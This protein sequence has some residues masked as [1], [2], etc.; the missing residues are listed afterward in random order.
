MNRFSISTISIA[1]FLLC[2]T[3]ATSALLA[4]APRDFAVTDFGALGDGTTLNTAAIQAAIDKAA[5]TPDGGRVVIP[6]GVFRSGSIFLKNGAELYL[7]AEA[8]LLGSNDIA[9]Y[10]KRDTR[11]EGHVE[12]WRMALVNAQNLPRVRI[13]GPGK[14][15]GNGA[16]FWAEFGRRIRENRKTTNLDVERPRLMFVDTCSDVRISGLVLRD[17]GFWNVHLY[18]CRDVVVED[19]DIAISR[20]KGRGPSTDGLDLDSCRDVIVRRCRFAVDD[21]CIAIKGSKGPLADRDE[22]SP[23]VENILIEKCTFDAGHGVVTFGSEATIVRGVTVRDC[24]VN[25]QNSVVRLKLRPD[26][27]QLYE[28][29]LYENIRLNADGGALISARPWLQYF[30]LKGH[31]SPPSVVRNLTIRNITGRYG[32]FGTLN[33][34]ANDIIDG[35]TL[36]NIDVTLQK[37]KLDTGAMVKNF[38][39][40]AVKVNGAKYEL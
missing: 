4:A 13:G 17:S 6:K 22:A 24:D 7:A 15:D 5:A 12:P 40:N 32:S 10:P 39:V 26:T 11:I 16:T 14:I 21:D 18:R 8:V 34:N 38:K 20:E 27:P 9:D 28:N 29:I 37:P 35:V 33:G 1:L 31:E 2:I 36:E 3:S 25:S 30:D 23:P 19:L